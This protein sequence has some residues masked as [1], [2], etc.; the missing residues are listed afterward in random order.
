MNRSASSQSV[1]G[2]V[3]VKK[4]KASSLLWNNAN[5]SHRTICTA[6]FSFLQQLDREVGGGYGD[7]DRLSR[8]L[9]HSQVPIN[10]W[11]SLQLFLTCTR[12]PNHRAT[13][14]PYGRKTRTGG[15]SSLA[16]CQSNTVDTQTHTNTHL[17]YTTHAAQIYGDSNILCNILFALTV[18]SNFMREY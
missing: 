7:T 16:G 8:W 2:S 18:L 12:W 5:P 17:H 11:L 10:L 1:Q 9:T 15:S 13:Q 4:V 6:C 3:R 14:S